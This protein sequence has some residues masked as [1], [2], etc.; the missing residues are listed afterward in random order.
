MLPSPLLSTLYMK[1]ENG[2][3]GD[4]SEQNEKVLFVLTHL[5]INGKI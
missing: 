2:M 4:S 3:S 1:G 5:K